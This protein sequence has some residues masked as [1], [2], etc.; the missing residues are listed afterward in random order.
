MERIDVQAKALNID[1]TSVANTSMGVPDAAG[2]YGLWALFRLSSTTG[3]TVAPTVSIGNVAASYSNIMPATPL[4][5]LTASA[6]ALPVFISGVVV[7]AG[8]EIFCRVS[9]AAT[10]VTYTF[11]ALLYGVRAND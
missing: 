8:A 9:V 7:L 2:I 10:A 3:L 5:A 4:T 1:G 6:F 11:D